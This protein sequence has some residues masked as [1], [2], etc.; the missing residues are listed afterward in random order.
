MVPSL[1][2]TGYY[3][4]KQNKINESNSLSSVLRLKTLN[5]TSLYF[6]N[7]LPK[8]PNNKKDTKWQFSFTIDFIDVIKTI[9]RLLVQLNIENT[10]VLP[11]RGHLGSEHHQRQ[12][13]MVSIHG[14]HRPE[15]CSGS[16]WLFKNTWNLVPKVSVFW[17]IKLLKVMPSKVIGLIMDHRSSKG[18]KHWPNV[19]LRLSLGF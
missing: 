18:F 5:S 2:L 17:E 7:T 3:R 6:Y 13:V 8:S 11:M 14:H 10:N 1:S 16:D 9:S 15:N 4:W 19:F 12:L